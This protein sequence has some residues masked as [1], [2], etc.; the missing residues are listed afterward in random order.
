MKGSFLIS[1]NSSEIDRNIFANKSSL[2]LHWLLVIG[3]EKEQFSI[4]E[5]AK[6]CNLSL[7]LVQRVFK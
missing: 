7:G 5:V 1:S 6:E 2:I 4:R 3:I